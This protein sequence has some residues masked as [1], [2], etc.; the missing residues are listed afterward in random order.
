[1]QSIF[2]MAYG[3]FIFGHIQK[4]GILMAFNKLMISPIQARMKQEARTK[5]REGEKV[6]K[7]LDIKLKSTIY[8]YIGFTVNFPSP[9]RRKPPETISANCYLFLLND[10]AINCCHHPYLGS[11]S[12]AELIQ[13][14]LML[15]FNRFE[16]YCF[17]FVWRFFLEFITEKKCEEIL[18]SLFST[19]FR[20]GHVYTVH[21]VPLSKQFE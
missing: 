11:N 20:H 1:M 21:S 9:P 2:S 5:E 4:G 13:Y 19:L 18:L 7:E 14:T 8:Y 10:E 6:E 16:S 3:I 12:I 15:M 17:S